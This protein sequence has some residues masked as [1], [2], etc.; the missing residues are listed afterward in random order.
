MLSRELINEL[1]RLNRTEKLRVVHILVH[2]LAIEEG[3][4]DLQETYEVW[5]PYD[6]PEAAAILTQMLQEDK[7]TYGE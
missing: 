3:V 5:S 4:L 7:E 6:A 2:E 1:R